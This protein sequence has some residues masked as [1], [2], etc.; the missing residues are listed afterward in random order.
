[1][2]NLKLVMIAAL[3]T[4][5][6]VGFAQTGEYIGKLKPETIKISLDEALA[7][8]GLVEAMYEQLDESMLDGEPGE[9]VVLKVEYKDVVFLIIGKRE[10]WLSFFEKEKVIIEEEK[11]KDADLKSPNGLV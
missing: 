11:D 2:K 6:S 1:M 7:M 9:V 5:T 8:P 3:I 4:F 10:A